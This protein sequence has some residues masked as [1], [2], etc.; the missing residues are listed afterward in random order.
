MRAL[1]ILLVLLVLATA[2]MTAA[3]RAAEPAPLDAATQSAARFADGPFG[4]GRAEY[5]LEDASRPTQANGD[6]AGS[7][8]RTLHT[9]AWYPLAADGSTLAPGPFPLLVW[10]HGF[11]GYSEEPEY[12]AR[13]L[14]SHGYVV[15]AADF[16]LTN[17]RAPGGPTVFDVVNQPGDVRF[18]I[19]TALAWNA[20]PAS[21]YAG[22]IDPARIA[23][24]GLSLG[25]MTTELTAWHPRLRDP[26]V[27]AAVSV[28]GPLAMFGRPFFAGSTL[29]FMMIAGDIDAMVPY[30]D[31]AR[32]VLERVDNAWLVSIRGASHTGFADQAS[33]LRLMDNPDAIGC[34][35]VKDKVP[36]DT[37]D[38]RLYALL[39]SEQEGILRTM[40][41][42]LCRLDPLPEAISPLLQQRITTLA[43]RSFLDTVFAA[44][45]AT[46]AAASQ[47][48]QASLA[49]ENP[50]TSVER[51]APL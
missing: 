4:A 43:V 19:D 47:Y 25:G 14:A 16:P 17:F 24:A 50:G 6:F 12:L 13:H 3:W 32:P 30:E 33:A 5:T 28:A 46:R 49:R 1:K 48:L 8:V 27:K 39:G 22:R 20:D 9:R 2:S 31:N 23:V 34:W 40:D 37:N 38:T 36:Q 29:P 7:P 18:L 41:H 35:F 26:R 44:D 11:S 51:S 15:L 45:D 42:R 10:S 21:P